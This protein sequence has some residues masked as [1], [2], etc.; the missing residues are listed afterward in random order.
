MHKIAY[1]RVVEHLKHVYTLLEEIAVSHEN[2]QRVLDE[3][4]TN[5]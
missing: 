4:T 2:S 3:R 5:H 1:N